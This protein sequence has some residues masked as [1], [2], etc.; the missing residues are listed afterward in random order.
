M[1]EKKKSKGLIWLIIILIL[2]IL[3]LIGFIIFNN[4]KLKN[5]NNL[6]ENTTTIPTTKKNIIETNEKIKYNDLV[7]LL[8]DYYIN[9]EKQE[10][11]SDFYD[12]DNVEKWNIDSIKYLGYYEDDEN[13]KYYVATGNFQC[14]DNG[15]TC[16]YMEQVDYETTDNIP[17]K[18]IFAIK[19]TENKYQ[20]SHMESLIFDDLIKGK[21]VSANGFVLVDEFINKEDI[22]SNQNVSNIV[23]KIK[24]LP[25]ENDN[26]VI[27]DGNIYNLTKDNIDFDTNFKNIEK[28]ENGFD[29]SYSCVLYGENNSDE[30]IDKCTKFKVIINKK[31]NDIFADFYYGLNIIF[32]ENY[33]IT[34]EGAYAGDLRI[35]DKS[36]NEIYTEY[37]ATDFGIKIDEDNFHNGIY[38][39]TPSIKD[40]KLYFIKYIKENDENLIIS[41]FDLNTRKVENILNF[42]GE[43]G[44]I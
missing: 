10:G 21:S 32:T 36:G 5:N 29:L 30:S 14:K 34:Y 41:N 28:N 12:D 24:S 17:F 20:L 18:A 39:Y 16:I 33:L 8:K 13:T 42:K 3:G 15:Y 7:K 9:Q 40:N 22:S 35:F 19:Q 4:V 27:W 43:I 25:K 23:N 1:E 26:S 44:A 6:N 2:L 37:I 38:G 11:I 31:D